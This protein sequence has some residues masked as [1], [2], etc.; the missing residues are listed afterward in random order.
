MQS[1]DCIWQSLFLYTFQKLMTKIQ[2]SGPIL[3]KV[4]HKKDRYRLR[5]HGNEE[6]TYDWQE[7]LRRF[8]RFID[9]S[10]PTSQ[11]LQSTEHQAFGDSLLC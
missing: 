2:T 11:Q 10:E 1:S 5:S 8:S 3:T 6:V 4:F 9:Y 7:N